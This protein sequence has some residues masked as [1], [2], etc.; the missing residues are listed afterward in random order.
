M[1]KLAFFLVLAAALAWLAA[2]DGR[3][4][5]A[6]AAGAV[7]EDE[8][9]PHRSGWRNWLP[10]LL[11]D[12]S[13][14][15][16]SSPTPPPETTTPPGPAGP[17]GPTAPT[18]PAEA[19]YCEPPPKA[20]VPT[21]LPLAGTPEQ[22]QIR[23][24]AAVGEELLA[25]G[26]AAFAGAT[27]ALA[28]AAGGYCATPSDRD[29][30][31]VREAWRCAM[32]AWQRVQH[33]RTG[34]VEGNHRRLRIQFF[35]DGN[36]AVERNLLGL[37][38][39]TEPIT[40][41]SVRNA[42][43]GAQ[44]F[45]ALEQLIFGSEALTPGSRRCEAAVAIAD[46]VRTMASEVASAWGEGGVTLGGFVSG[47]APFISQDDVLIAILE[48]VAIQAEFVADQKIRDALRTG[49][50]S[51]LES[52]L[53][54]QS[55]ENVAANLSALADLIDDERAGAY[56]L[57]DYLRR[58][59]DDEAVGNQLASVATTMQERVAA[60]ADSFED[61]V[62][63]GQTAELQ[64]LFNDLQ[65]LSDLAVDASVVANVNL[66]FNSEDGD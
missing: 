22:E 38:D 6:A 27:A 33:L 16:T 19:D 23:F 11:R 2:G 56:R 54:A 21:A 41:A 34:P 8:S 26:H 3:N 53:A 40:E 60:M 65:Q 44:G 46:N 63:S 15:T 57:R 29:V 31:A 43:A 61:I 5:S 36:G 48:S 59:H 52:P 58:A 14:E 66:G 49:D 28:T 20:A 17:P 18:D 7:G 62:A 64:L 30:A 45:P 35:P 24:F 55:K 39:G 10:A 32:V 51:V 4:A 37:L 12:Q 9:P 42:P 25:P 1:R 50:A 47:S 13:E